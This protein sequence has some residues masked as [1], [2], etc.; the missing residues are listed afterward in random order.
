VK[1]KSLVSITVA[2]ALFACASNNRQH[3]AASNADASSYKP[4]VVHL[5]SARR[6]GVPSGKAFLTHLARGKNA[7]LGRLEMAANGSVPLHQDATEEYIHILEGSGTMTIDGQTYEVKAGTTVYMPAMAKVTFQNG[8][9]E[10][11][12][13]Q[14]FA[15]PEPAAK[16][17]KWKEVKK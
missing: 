3:K 15:G 8:P 1:K 11:V 7:F 10:L 2:L 14:V 17:E 9:E 13:L 5:E 6:V 4:Q 16:Y 12:A